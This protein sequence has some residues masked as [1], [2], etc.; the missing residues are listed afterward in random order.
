MRL[1]SVIAAVGIAGSSVCFGQAGSVKTHID[2]VS[3]AIGMNMAA[4]LLADSIVLNPDMVRAGL[5]DGTAGGR[6]QLSDSAAAMVLA[7]FQQELM[8]RAQERMVREQAA[9]GVVNLQQGTQFLEANKSRPGV[10]VTR[11]GL[12]YIVER[13]GEGTPPDLND[14]VKVNYRGTLIDGTE[15]DRSADGKPVEFPVD[16]VIA[17]WVEALQMMKP[18]AKWKLFIPASLAYGERGFGGG[19]IGPNQTLVFEVELVSVTRQ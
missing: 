12:Q 7:D 4:S 19:R 14:I 6:T 8:A 18:G 11:T 17:G 13:E 10:K 3:Y 2:S 15:F 1:A 16:G 5:V 9:Q